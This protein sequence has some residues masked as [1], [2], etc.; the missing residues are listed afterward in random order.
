MIE[1]ENTSLREESPENHPSND[2]DQEF[3][4]PEEEQIETE[5]EGTGELEMES[6]FSEAE[7]LSSE[8][9]HSPE[10]PSE[11]KKGK[12]KK[13]NRDNYTAQFEVFL[14]EFQNQPD[15]EAKLQ[16]AIQF[17]ELSL[18]QGGTPH[19][20]NF[21][22]ARRL[23]LPLFKENISPALRSQLWTT[24]SDL[25]KEARRLKEL[26]DEQSS[27][28]VEQIEIAILALEK[29]I[30][31]PIENDKGS[32]VAFNAE[33]FPQALE[34]KQ[35]FYQDIQHQLNILNVQ[36]SR[37]NALRKELL[38][39]EMRVRQKNK[40]FQRLSSAGD[41]VF[42]KRK[43]L[44]KQISTQFVQDV[45]HFIQSNFKTNL[46]HEALYHL[47][48][49]IKALQGLAKV[50]TLNT[51][52]FT[53][54]RTRLSECWDTLKIEEKERKKERAQQRSVFRQNAE[55]VQQRIQ[56]FKEKFLSG[57]MNLT[58]AHKG[59]DDIVYFMRQVDLGRDELKV[60]RESLADARKPIQDKI[61]ADEDHR[62]HQ[63]QERTRQ[64]REKYNALK[65]QADQLITQHE[66]HEVDQLVDLRDKLLVQ[67]NESSLTKS[68]KQEIERVL[69]PL[70]DIITDKKEKAL[71]SLSE[72]DRQAL[73]QLKEIL[74]QRKERRL[75]IK[76]QLEFFKKASSAS[77]LDFEKAMN[78]HTQMDEEKQRLE[79][80][81]Q[82][83]K[84]IEQKLAEL[85]SKIKGL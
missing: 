29:E 20:R 21:W 41:H 33:F 71:L 43:E 7:S 36:A 84:E 12:P 14:A 46:S 65:E 34:E 45:E 47:R 68:E 4:M 73:Q 53:Q 74:Q 39:T 70:R 18:A 10:T 51:S 24:Y 85:Q 32:T 83:I 63:E 38:K 42:P 82:G 54:T 30:E 58:D 78:Y 15:A 8:E 49:E 23:C 66:T 55:E 52:S 77:G 11:S 16:M 35:A 27:F 61:K 44:I 13:D 1:S 59:I 26:L 40:F 17:M 5:S 50:L 57:T 19:F 62:L 81:N 37:I 22:E 69:K 6:D 75:E 60:L 56:A 72:D 67:V 64:K 3:I 25:S 9:N 48:E 2:Q 76:N 28:A 80:A 79:K 31:Q